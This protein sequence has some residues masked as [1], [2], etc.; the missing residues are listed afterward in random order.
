MI[1]SNNRAG[2]PMSVFKNRRRKSS[3]GNGTTPSPQ[4]DCQSPELANGT[5][6]NG[7]AGMLNTSSSP[8]ES[9]TGGGANGLGIQPVV[10]PLLNFSAGSSMAVTNPYQAAAAVAAAVSSNPYANFGG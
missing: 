9:S 5:I 4:P 1:D 2:R 8:D 3:G 10:D 6:A 7:S